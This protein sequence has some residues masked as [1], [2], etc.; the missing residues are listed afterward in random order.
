M[1]MEKMDWKMDK[2]KTNQM[3][4]YFEN[5]YFLSFGKKLFRCAQKFYDE[6]INEY[7]FS[8][9]PSNALSS[10]LILSMK[11]LF[12]E[13]FLVEHFKSFLHCHLTKNCLALLIYL[14]DSAT[15]Y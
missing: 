2:L 8:L 9:F 10:S 14:K 6:I 11:A 5:M 15:Y 7:T 13:S 3:S 4:W 12:A 1:M